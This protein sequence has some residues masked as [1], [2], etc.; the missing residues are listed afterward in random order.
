MTITMV[1][2]RSLIR[3]ITG[4]VAAVNYGLKH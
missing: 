2:C 3:I 1:K 4:E